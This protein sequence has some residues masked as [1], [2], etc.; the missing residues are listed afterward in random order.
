MRKSITK[1][2]LSISSEQ[3]VAGLEVAMN[4]K[5]LVQ[6][7]ESLADLVTNAAN[8]RLCQRLLKFLHDTVHRTATAELYIHLPSNNNT[9]MCK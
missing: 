8:L 6:E 5:V 9:A 7:V 4:D 3:N 1:S 2:D